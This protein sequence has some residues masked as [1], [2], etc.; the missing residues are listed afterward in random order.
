[1]P[2]TGTLPALNPDGGR[3]PQSPVSFPRATA[4]VPGSDYTVTPSAEIGNR[5]RGGGHRS[6]PG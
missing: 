3:Y 6:A 1:M 4:R 2:G 5:S